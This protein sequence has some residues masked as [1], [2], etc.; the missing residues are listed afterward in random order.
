MSLPPA[1]ETLSGT[2]LHMMAQHTVLRVT[3]CK[4]P[5]KGAQTDTNAGSLQDGGCTCARKQGPVQIANRC[6]VTFDRRPDQNSSQI[7]TYAISLK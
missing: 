4:Y 7:H 3:R 6:C 1:R 2:T 5:H